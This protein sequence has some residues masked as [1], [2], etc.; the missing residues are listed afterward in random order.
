VRQCGEEEEAGPAP[1]RRL[2][3]IISMTSLNVRRK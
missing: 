2:R 1:Q 3:P